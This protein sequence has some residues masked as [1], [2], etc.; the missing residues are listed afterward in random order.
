[1][2]NAQHWYEVGP[3][4]APGV[5]RLALEWRAPDDGPSAKGK[6]SKRIVGCAERRNPVPRYQAMPTGPLAAAP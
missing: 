1:M 4:R 5:V 6:C 2:H 3:M